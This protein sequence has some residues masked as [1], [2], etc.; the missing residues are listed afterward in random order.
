MSTVLVSTT[1]GSQ[2]AGIV[3]QTPA[4]RGHVVRGRAYTLPVLLS[5]SVARYLSP[6]V[7][8]SATMS[9]NRSSSP[10]G[11]SSMPHHEHFLLNTRSPHNTAT[12]VEAAFVTRAKPLILW[13]TLLVDPLPGSVTLTSQVHRAWLEALNHISDT[14][15]MEASEESLKI[16][17][18]HRYAG[19]TLP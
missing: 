19:M 2:V 6:L 1:S 5:S 7:T 17:N 15:N 8:H 16:V 12:R 9:G 13:Y 14:G 4:A 10:T 11:E 3:R 18:E